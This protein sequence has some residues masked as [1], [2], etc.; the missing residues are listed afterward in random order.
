[1]KKPVLVSI[2]FFSIFFV[3][4]CDNGIPSNGNG[5][6][7]VTGVSLD[8]A[9][10]S[11]TIDTTTQ[12]TCTVEPSDA[13]DKS[14]SWESSDS[15]VATVDSGGI[16]T[17]VL[18]GE[19]TITVTTTDGGYSD[20]CD[21]SVVIAGVLDTTF[22]SVGYAVHH[23]AAGGGSSDSGAAIVVD[24][25]GRILVTGSSWNGSNND[26]A[27]WRYNGDGT[28]DTT[29][30]STGYAVHHNAAGGNGNDNGSAIAIDGDGKIV[31]AGSSELEAVN[32]PDIAVWRYNS[33]GTLDTTFNSVGYVTHNNAGGAGGNT[34]DYAYGMVID[35]NGKI[36][37][38][39]S[40][41][42]TADT[43]M[44]I[45][46]F[47]SNGTLDTS[48]D[49]D[50]FAVYDDT[51]TDRDDVGYGVAI[52]GN[53]KIVVAGRYTNG[54]KYDMAVWCYNND[55][56]IDTSF[57]T[58]GFVSHNDAA[59]GN[60]YD[61]GYAVT[62]D[63]D[64]K[65]V[66]AGSSSATLGTEDDMV[67]WRYNTNGALDTTFNAVGYA[68]Y[69]GNTTAGDTG[70]AVAIDGQGRIYVAGFIRRMIGLKSDMIVWR[71]TAD[72]ALDTTFN[73]VGC[74]EHDS[75]AG[76]ADTDLGYGVTIDQSGRILVTGSSN[77]GTTGGDMVIWRY[78]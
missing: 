50:G 55:G 17:G 1:M 34:W 31:V 41:N 75:A 78:K 15:G 35:N 16:V 21:V 54:G 45:W 56:S 71:Y 43:E 53:G 65:I 66:V 20:T 46:R 36:V 11:T 73:S 30:N 19:P 61:Y 2:V 40:S 25:D 3:L 23:N 58:T 22:N 76:G 63:A 42:S 37:V 49:A 57:N 64:G 29:F 59:G 12:L 74:V 44:V 14:V 27:I 5:T 77:G 24:G 33:D 4:S 62:V 72:G 60:G 48:F 68:V 32:A 6:V 9:G 7:A 52:D 69:G 67:I 51:G 8:T 38:T 26:M 13:T 39:G 18:E 47:N 70:R 10:F 28:L